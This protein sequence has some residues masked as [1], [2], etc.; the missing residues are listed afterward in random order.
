M[1]WLVAI[2]LGQQTDPP[3]VVEVAPTAPV[4]VTDVPERFRGSYVEDAVWV[5][6]EFG[7]LGLAVFG[8]GI[9]WVTGG[10]K[11]IRLRGFRGIPIS[12][13]VDLT[14]GSGDVLHQAIRGK[15]P[16]SQMLRERM[17][18]RKVLGLDNDPADNSGDDDATTP[19]DSGRRGP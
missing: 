19:T 1:I 9:L 6:R 8:V 11:S 7:W 4:V 13:R 18:A 14:H 10:L 15:R 3:Q 17:A 5:K 16:P 12:V 2:A